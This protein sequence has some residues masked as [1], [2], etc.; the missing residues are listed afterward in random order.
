MEIA[1]PSAQLTFALSANAQNLIGLEMLVH[2]TCTNM[3]ESDIKKAIDQSKDAGIQNLLALRGYPVRGATSFDECNRGF[4]HGVD[5][6]RYIRKN[7]GN[8]FCIGVTRYPEGHAESHQDRKA[9]I[10]YLKEKVEDGADFVITQL[11]YNVQVYVDFVKE[12]RAADIKVLIIPGILPIQNYSRFERMN[13]FCKIFVPLEVVEALELIKENDEAV[14]DYGVQLSITMIQQRIHVG[15]PGLHFYTLNIERSAFRR[16]LIMSHGVNFLGSRRR[17]QNVRL[18][19]VR[20]IYWSNRPK[21][22]MHRTAKWNEYPSGCW[23]KSPPPRVWR[24]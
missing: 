22:Y 9:C 3:S 1:A 20:P 8:H 18:K 6:V 2:M 13:S 15:G 17:C 19:S 23:G 5:L 14:K 16:S 10:Q 4:G 7:Y 11:F 24:D 12:C 21:S